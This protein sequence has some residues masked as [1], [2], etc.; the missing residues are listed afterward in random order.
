MTPARALG[1]LLAATMVVAGALATF[2]GLGGGGG[3][4]TSAALWGPLLAG[5]GVALAISVVGSARRG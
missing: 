5:L 3:E 1:L 2:G 4:Q